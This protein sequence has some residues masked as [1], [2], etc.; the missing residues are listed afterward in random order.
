MLKKRALLLQTGKFVSDD[1]E[2]Q[3]EQVINFC[4]GYAK[5]ELLDHGFS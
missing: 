1:I 5:L 4:L 3:T 2:E